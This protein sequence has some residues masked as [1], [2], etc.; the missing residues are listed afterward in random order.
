MLENS[1][2]LTLQRQIYNKHEELHSSSVID[3][4]DLVEFRM[5]VTPKVWPAVDYCNR[6]NTGEKL[7]K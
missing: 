1:T 4:S 5:C 6:G 2:N 3:D 7:H